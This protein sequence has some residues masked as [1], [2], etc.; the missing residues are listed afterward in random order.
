MQFKTKLKK[1]TKKT[2]LGTGEWSGWK[3]DDS[4]LSAGM[5]PAAQLCLGPKDPFGNDGVGNT[6]LL[7]PP[8]LC[9]LPGMLPAVRDLS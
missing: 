6:G 8:R 7:G 5:K 4:Q 1:S 3:T 9:W 2:K